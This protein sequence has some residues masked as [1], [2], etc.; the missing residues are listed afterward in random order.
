MTDE[1]PSRRRRRPAADDLKEGAALHYR[2]V[3]EM[4]GTFAL[5]FV[6][7]GADTIA[8]ITNGEV[9]PAARAVA[10]GLLIMAFVY[11]LGDTSGA[12]F[13]PVVTLGFALRRLF[14]PAWVPAYWLAQLTG[15]I[16]AALLL[17]A[18]FGDA[19]AAG[20]STPHV[21]GPVAVVIEVVLAWLLLTVILGTA[22]RA[23][24]IGPNA[25]IAVGATIALCGLV[26]LPIEG[27]SMN[28][29]RSLGPALVNGRLG[30]TW[31]YV[32]GPALGMAVAVAA[33][34]YL[35]G[36]QPRDEKEIEAATGERR[37][38]R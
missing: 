35:H 12:H 26:A 34:W 13:N 5:T 18:L 20:I 28:P 23:R 37:K 29:A 27:A 33:T 1:A 24:L 6:A 15:A 10:P 11:A 8:S 9:T 19:A 17:R 32:V 38:R 7:A 2:L 16:A 31:I 14:P 22:D 4:I 30:D 36:A 3:A 25:A 21:S